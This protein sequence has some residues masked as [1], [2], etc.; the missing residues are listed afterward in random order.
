MRAVEP[1]EAPPQPGPPS[2]PPDRRLGL[3]LLGLLL[4]VLAGL[5]AGLLLTRHGAG[6]STAATTSAAP[7]TVSTPAVHIRTA[8]QTSDQAAQ[9]TAGRLV[10]MKAPLAAARLAHK[11][12]RSKLTLV[13]S[14][15][16]A[17]VVLA[18]APP[19]GKKL[20]TGSLVV[21]RV[22]K[23]QSGLLVPDVT[24]QAAG[25]AVALLRARGLATDVRGVQSTQARGSV[26]AQQPSAGS[27]ATKGTMI[28]LSVSRGTA[29]AAKTVA[30]SSQA[31]GAA[32]VPS[33][34]GQ[35]VGAARRSLRAVGLVAEVRSVPSAQ[36]TGT[37]VGQARPA[38]T[39]LKRGD[40]VLLTVSQGAPKA[41]L[42]DLP[43]VTGEDEASAR[44]RLQSAGFTVTSQDAPTTDPS[45]D[46]VVVDQ[47]P[48][49]GTKQPHG[50]QVV[51]TV[52]RLTTTT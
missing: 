48:D 9:V 23:G 1:G 11:G 52:G 29:S 33:V 24:G 49:G 40:H 6:R 46:G 21:L 17:G 22:S 5:A 14:A 42:F 43:D 7:P 16:P 26:V 51:I 38:G 50:S 8:A 28:V 47:Q 3:W 39:A 15:K 10:G 12:L 45:Q 20:M 13:S 25:D 41:Q 36:A 44:S 30:S 34:V 2:T 27:R 35:D 37:V 19:A 32:T 31:Q 4:L 18:Q